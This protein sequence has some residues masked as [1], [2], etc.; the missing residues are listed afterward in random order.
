MSDA[1]SSL[2]LA[3]YGGIDRNQV[4]LPVSL[5]KFHSNAQPT[6]GACGTSP[7]IGT[8]YSN[9]VAGVVN[10]GT[11]T[12]SSCTVNFASTWGNPPIV[13]LQGTG[14]V[15]YYIT[16][17]SATSFTFARTDG[18]NMASLTVYYRA[19]MGGN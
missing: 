3:V 5:G 15:P 11:G 8:G 1:S 17:Q 13:F 7:S 16:G 12:F 14:S 18:G 10:T 4:A 19:T 2:N 6:F 9:D